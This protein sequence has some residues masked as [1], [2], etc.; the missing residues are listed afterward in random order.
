MKPTYLTLTAS[1]TSN[2]IPLDWR[3]T[4][5]TVSIG[6]VKGGALLVTYSIEYTLDP[7]S[8]ND[9]DYTTATWVPFAEATNITSNV[10]FSIKSPVRAI[11]VTA[12]ILASTLRLQIVSS[13]HC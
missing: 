2:P 10:N 4:Y 6:A 3:D 5:F 9:P 7:L 1:G 8:T 11:R 13:G 12:A